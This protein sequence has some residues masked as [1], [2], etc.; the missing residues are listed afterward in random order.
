M[1]LRTRASSV[2]KAFSTLP[3]CSMCS[4]RSFSSALKCW[5]S[6]NTSERSCLAAPCTT[7]SNVSPGLPR[8]CETEEPSRVRRTL[9]AD[10]MSSAAL[11]SSPL[12]CS[13]SA[14]MSA[15][16]FSASL[17]AERLLEYRAS[18]SSAILTAAQAKVEDETS[19]SV[20]PSVEPQKGAVTSSAGNP[21]RPLSS[22]ASCCRS[23]FSC[24]RSLKMSA[25]SLERSW[26]PSAVSLCK[27]S[28]SRAA[29]I[30][31]AEVRGLSA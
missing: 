31:S 16:S 24:R 27:Y 1:W 15:G 7:A 5:R 10:L 3:A 25:G 14:N 20:L 17:S 12:S 18:R 23:P 28:S 29:A 22:P 21:S 2:W 9:P 8:S 13:S 6:E 19:P 11:A 4:A 30:S 26:S